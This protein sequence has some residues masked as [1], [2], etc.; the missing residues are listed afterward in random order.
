M[1]DQELVNLALQEAQKSNEP[2]RCGVVIAKDGQ[3]IVATYNSQREDYNATAHA[4][5]K[6]IAQA[7]AQLGQKDLTGCAA[8]CSCEPCTMCLSAMIFAK[9]EKVYFSTY[10]ADVSDTYIKI[11]SQ[12]LIEKAPRKIEIIKI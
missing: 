2:L 4:E 8:Y 3:V 1:T 6:A 5:I 9:I 7:G 11:D 12:E 10:L